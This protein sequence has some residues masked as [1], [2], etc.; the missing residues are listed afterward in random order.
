MSSRINLTDLIGPAYYEAH[1]DVRNE[2]HTYYDLYGGRG[3]LKSSFVSLEIVQGIV[4]DPG[5]SAICFRRVKDTLRESVYAQIGWAIEVLGLSDQFRTFTTPLKYVYKP[6]G[7]VI[8]FR[9]LDDPLKL[10]SIKCPKGYYKYLWLEELAEYESE[11]VI[12]SVQ[13]S[14]LR[15]GTSFIVFRTFNPP[16]NSNNWTNKMVQIPKKDAYRL[17]TTYLQSPKEWLG[18]VFLGEAEF[19]KKT[20]YKAYQHEYLGEAVGTGRQIFILLEIRTITDEE[21][22]SMDRFYNGLDWGWYPDPLAFTRLA[23]QSAQRKLFAIDE[24]YGN[25]IRNDDIA[26]QIIQRGYNDV[27]TTCDSAEPKSIQD[28][29]DIGVWARPAIKGPGSVEYGM[30]WMQARTLVI[31]PMRTPNLYREVTEYEHDV[32]KDGTIVPGFPDRGNHTIDSMRYG[33]EQVSRS[34]GESA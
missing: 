30:K 2:M 13:Q 21:I 16:I 22:K 17:K 11:E 31:D 23:Y 15:G 3:S 29:K 14:V 7:Q 19:L 32:K 27:Y 25:F 10:K 34:R 28:I 1:W 33:T 9:G 6:T 24:I 26:R 4:R 12:R 8:S 20:N 18:P 5:V